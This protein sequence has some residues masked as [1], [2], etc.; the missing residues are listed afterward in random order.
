VASI[1]PRRA[2]AIAKLLGCVGLTAASLYVLYLGTLAFLFSRQLYLR[3]IIDASAKNGRGDKVSAETNIED[4]DT[5][6]WKTAIR[7]KR[8]G[9]LFP[10]TLLEA[11]S[12]EIFVGLKWQDNNNLVLQLDFGCDGTNSIPV[13][14][15]GPIHI[16]YQFGDPGYAADPGYESAPRRDPHAPCD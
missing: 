12:Y 3:N 6:P 10:T 2:A 5:H 16:R 7:L 14:A 11:R 13:E 1:S 15:V 8:T 4:G 9:H